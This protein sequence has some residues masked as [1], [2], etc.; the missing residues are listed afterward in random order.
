MSIGNCCIDGFRSH[1]YCDCGVAGETG[2]YNNIGMNGDGTLIAVQI[3]DMDGVPSAYGVRIFERSGTT[4]TQKQEIA[5]N[6]FDNYMGFIALSKDGNKL[7]YATYSDI[8][9]YTRSGETW[10]LT[11]TLPIRVNYLGVDYDGDAYHNYVKMSDDAEVIVYAGGYA[12]LGHD[13]V[14][15]WDHGVQH[16]VVDTAGSTYFDWAAGVSGDGRYVFTGT[17][18]HP[19][20]TVSVS[21]FVYTTINLRPG[22]IK[23]YEKIGGTWTQIDLIYMPESAVLAAWDN[24]W[25]IDH[26]WYTEIVSSY[27]GSVIAFSNFGEYYRED[28]VEGSN[29][30]LSHLTLGMVQ[31]FRKSGATWEFEQLLNNP[32]ANQIQSEYGAGSAFGYSLHMT[33]DGSRLAASSQG[34]TNTLWD[35]GTQWTL[36]RVFDASDDFENRTFGTGYDAYAWSYGYATRISSDG[37]FIG[38]YELGFQ[39][40]E[41]MRVWFYEECE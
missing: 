41:T 33:S 28:T 27:D 24:H 39:G 40:D 13:A 31:M 29:S 7:V 35:Y 9:V 12:G 3:E 5:D 1:S 30:S 8:K 10:S 32:T 21:S 20:S 16:L 26:Y 4:W 38:I 18:G 37:S 14:M 23:V 25:W 11:A 22:A 36:T 17:D 15:I 2:N 19:D 6:D 34:D